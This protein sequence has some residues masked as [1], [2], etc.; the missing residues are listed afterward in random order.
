[1]GVYLVEVPHSAEECPFRAPE[2]DAPP[3]L[4]STPASLPGPRYWGCDSGIHT[5]WLIAE[6]P[7]DGAEAVAWTF[8]PALL[9]DT[10]RVIRVSLDQTQE[11]FA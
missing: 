7:A 2:A 3:P 5:S 9:R 1:V 4:D 8:V 10:A 11:V 6:L